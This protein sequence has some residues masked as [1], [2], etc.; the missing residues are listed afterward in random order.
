[1][2]KLDKFYSVIQELFEG[3]RLRGIIVTAEKPA[4]GDMTLAAERPRG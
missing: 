1:M 4:A 2:G 3:T